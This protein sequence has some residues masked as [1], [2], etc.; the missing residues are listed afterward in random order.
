MSPAALSEPVRALGVGDHACWSFADEDQLCAVATGFVAAG[1]AAG[2]RVLCVVDGQLEQLRRALGPLEPDR[3]IEQGGLEL[4]VVD[5]VYGDEAVDADAQLRTFAQAVTRAEDDGFT[6]LRVLADNTPLLFDRPNACEAYLRWESVCEPFIASR[7]LIG[8]CC[9]DERRVTGELAG[10]LASVHR[11]TLD[12]TAAPFGLIRVPDRLTL[13]GDLD[14]YDAE[15]LGRLLEHTV[16]ADEDVVLDLQ[17]VVFL[18]HHAL[19]SFLAVRD[20]LRAHGRS[21]QLLNVPSATRRL[22]GHLGVEL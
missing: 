22:A 1:V 5:E 3:L 8:L 2:Q 6:G 9:F 14:W 16:A 10:D 21:L 7:R 12:D 15:R 11:K 19:L 17:E 13:R 18:D 20:R 4:L